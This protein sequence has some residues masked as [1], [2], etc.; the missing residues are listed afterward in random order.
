LLP[1]II[2]TTTAITV[3]DILVYDGLTHKLSQLK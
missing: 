1:V 2:G 3:A